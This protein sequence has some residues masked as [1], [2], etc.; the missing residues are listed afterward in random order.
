[1]VGYEKTLKGGKK[2][3]S[4]KIGRKLI[5]MAVLHA[6]KLGFEEAATMMPLF[7]A[8]FLANLGFEDLSAIPQ[9]T[10]CAKTIKE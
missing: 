8:S 6:P 7:V 3:V 5:A 4:T 2:A 10:P 9:Q 1:M